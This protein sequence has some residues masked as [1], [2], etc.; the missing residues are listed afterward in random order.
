ME[1]VNLIEISHDRYKAPLRSCTMQ[2]A[3]D[4]LTAIPKK[5]LGLYLKKEKS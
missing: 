2:H 3:S 1:K 4:W 5:N